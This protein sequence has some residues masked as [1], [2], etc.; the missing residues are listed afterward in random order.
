M[1]CAEGKSIELKC[2]WTHMY[3]RLADSPHAQFGLGRSIMHGVLIRMTSHN[4][5]LLHAT[6]SGP[7]AL[8]YRGFEPDRAS[9]SGHMNACGRVFARD[10]SMGLLWY[11]HC[12]K[13]WTGLVAPVDVGWDCVQLLVRGSLDCWLAAVV[14][15]WVCWVELQQFL[16]GRGL[17]SLRHNLTIVRACVSHSL[18]VPCCPVVLAGVATASMH[19]CYCCRYTLV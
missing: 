9:Q 6:T 14:L 11:W 5:T 19:G 10:I 17:H 3:T 4:V 2:G 8:K 15:G 13:L 16:S 1:C 12:S 7:V 18:Q